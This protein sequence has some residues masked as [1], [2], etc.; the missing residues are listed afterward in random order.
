MK[1]LTNGQ[2]IKSTRKYLKMRQE[3][4]T[5][6]NITRG[7][8]SMIEIG[9]R[10]LN[11]KVALTLVEKFKKRAEELDIS[12]DISSEFLLRSPAEDAELYC[13]KKI[14]EVNNVTEINQL[15]E[16][17][18]KFN[19]TNI[20]AICNEQSGDYYYNEKDYYNAFFYYNC[21]IDILKNI[22]QNEKIAHLYLK[23]GLCNAMLLSYAQAL[24]FFHLSNEYAKMYKDKTIEKRS[25]YNGSKCYME[26]KK[27]EEA[28]KYINLYLT[29]I[30]KENEFID[31][32]NAIILKAN[33]YEAM[34]NYD[35]A[36]TTYQSLLNEI[37]SDIPPLG[38]I[39][40]N[41][42]LA[43][44]NKDDL[45]NSLK[46]FNMAEEF[47]LKTNTTNLSHTIIEK[48]GVFIKQGHLN[49]AI[50]LIES[51]LR[52]AEIYIDYEYILKGISELARIY[53][54]LHS[55]SKLKELYFNLIKIL[56]KLNKHKELTIVYNKLSIIYLEENNIDEAK[57]YILMTLEL[58][59]NIP[60]TNYIS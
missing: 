17:A 16:I 48:S 32:V 29:L 60:L 41:L 40:N 58:N 51:G 2:K 7:L 49:D 55:T 10:E 18:D 19:L 53:E 14:E 42:G 6:D 56:N 47:K 37:T 43:Y 25:L 24:S 54:I 57:K 4:L 30:N 44:L 1:F 12:L 36:I 50:E 22:N 34:L 11:S 45:T 33:C 35:I 9:K 13:I 26:L 15:L 5:D 39:Y 46:Y 31:Y 8:I 3:D 27:T 20:K 38:Y 59:K 21:S 52:L 23:V 28:L